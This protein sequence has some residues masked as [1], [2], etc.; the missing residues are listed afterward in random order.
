LKNFYHHTAIKTSELKKKQDKKTKTNISNKKYP[1]IR[2][3][4]C[5]EQST[6]VH[7]D[8]QQQNIS[9]STKNTHNKLHKRAIAFDKLYT[10]PGDTLKLLLLL[11][12]AVIHFAAEKLLHVQKR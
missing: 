8:I 4:C 2:D 9:N 1:P 12:F 11:F 5:I 7:K 10:N 3:R 6:H